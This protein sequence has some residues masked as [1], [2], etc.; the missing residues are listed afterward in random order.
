MLSSP[1]TGDKVEVDSDEFYISI[2]KRSVEVDTL[3]IFRG[4]A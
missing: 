3:I 4:G 2:K 1:K